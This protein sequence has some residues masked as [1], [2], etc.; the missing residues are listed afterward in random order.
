MELLFSLFFWIL[1]FLLVV[2]FFRKR[3][4][5]IIDAEIRAVEEEREVRILP[6]YKVKHRVLNISE[7][8]FF[9]ILEK[10]IGDDFF[11]FPNMRIA[12]VLQTVNGE[13]YYN[14]LNRILP[15]HIDFLICDLQFRPLLAI[16]LDGKYHNSDAQKEKDRQKDEI[17][18]KAGLPLR[19]VVVGSDFQQKN[20]GNKNSR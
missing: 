10:E 13:G 17:F 5:R 14:R 15:K 9:Y 4:K 18:K 16:E 3:V 1:L 20:R 12:D 2:L 11:I 7:A 6:E 8:S 19:R